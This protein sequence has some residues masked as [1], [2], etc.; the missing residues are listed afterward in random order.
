VSLH[1][2]LAGTVA[3]LELEL[4]LEVARGECLAIAGPS[5]AGKSTILRYIAGIDTPSKGVI[6]CGDQLWLDTTRSVSWS[7]ERRRCGLLFQD[8]ALFPHLSAW[9]NVAYGLARLPRAQRKTRALELLERFEV[10][11]RAHA[12]PGTLSGGER[13]RVALAR[14]L[15][16]APE[17]LL[18]D[19]P[20]AALDARTRAAAVRSLE[21]I[22]RETGTPV[23]VVTHDFH[24]AAVLGDEVAVLDRGRIIQRGRPDELAAQPASAFVADFTGAVVLSGIAH[25]APGGLTRIELDGGGEAVATD[26]AEGRVAVSVYPWEITLLSADVPAAGSAQNRLRARVTSIVTVGNR[27]RVGLQAGQPLVAEVTQDSV[28]ELALGVGASVSVAWKATAT[29]LVAL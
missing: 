26:P 3:D 20:C 25:P 17:L 14:A 16:R 2:E 7:A 18:L 5:G 24:E 12:R 6:A 28:R 15:A 8:Y 13:Q 4:S 27:A 29:R 10:G 23:V 22:L 19:E 11:H 21:A 1:A 9:R